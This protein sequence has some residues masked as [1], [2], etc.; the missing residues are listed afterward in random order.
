[1]IASLFIEEEKEKINNFGLI[2][3]M[4]EECTEGSSTI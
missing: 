1:M 4:N 3:T 2:T